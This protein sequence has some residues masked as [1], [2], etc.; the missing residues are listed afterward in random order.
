MALQWCCVSRAM[1]WRMAD[2]ASGG[3]ALRI[4]AG[5]CPRGFKNTA[6][7]PGV[8]VMEFWRNRVRRI[9]NLDP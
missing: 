5:G 7:W 2:R 6:Y 8:G 3:V 4:L 1:L 9:A